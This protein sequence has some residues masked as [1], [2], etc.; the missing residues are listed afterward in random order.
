MMVSEPDSGWQD[1]LHQRILVKDATAFAELCEV[2]LPHLVTFLRNRFSNQE[3]H[4]FEM[5]AIDTLLAYQARPQQYNPAR[6]SLFSFLRMATRND[7]INLLDKKGR[8]ERRLVDIDDPY[9]QSGIPPAAP[10][11]EAESL[12]DWLAQH[13]PL[14][15]QD[16]LQ[17]LDTELDEMDRELIQLMLEGV[18]DSRPYASAMGISHLDTNHQRAEVKRAKDRLTKKLRRFGDKLDNY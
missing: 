18:R 16:V 9:V 13:T 5:A 17:A 15:R 3:I 7:M 2:A 6:L 1:K 8:R 4:L 10:V 14:S 11:D 12:D